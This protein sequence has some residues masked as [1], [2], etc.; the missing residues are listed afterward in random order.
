M[1][2]L[3][4]VHLVDRLFKKELGDP[5]RIFI[6]PP[7]EQKYLKDASVDLMLGNHFIVT[8]NARFSALDARSPTTK[9]DI[10]SYQE[11]VYVPFHGRPLVLHPGTFVLGVTWQYIGLPNNVYAQVFS[12]STWGRTGLT[13]ATAVSVHPGFCGC[14]T[15]ELVNHGNAPVDLYPGSRLAQIVFFEVDQVAQVE[16]PSHSKYCGLIEPSFSRLYDE[17]EELRQLERIGKIATL[18]DKAI[19]D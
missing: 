18:Q 7:P 12:R 19:A 4:S 16:A 14:L 3:S 2:V 11:R 8:K 17:L 5:N 9:Q 13:V 15:L 1:G 6:M 10:A